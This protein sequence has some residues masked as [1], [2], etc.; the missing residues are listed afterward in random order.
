MKH[1]DALARRARRSSTSQRRL[2]FSQRRHAGREDD[3][4]AVAADVA[5]VRQIRDL[6]RGNLESLRSRARA[7]RSTLSQSNAVEKKLD[8][9]ALAMGHQRLMHVARTAPAGAASR[10]AIHRR[11]TLRSDSPLSRRAAVARRSALKVWNLTKSAPA[12]GGRFDQSASQSQVAVMVD[13]GLGDDECSHA[14]PLERGYC[15]CRPHNR[16]GPLPHADQAALCRCGAL[17]HAGVA[18]DER[19][20]S[21]AYAAVDGRGGRDV[22]VVADHGVMLHQRL[23]VDDAIAARPLRRR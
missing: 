11:P 21:D 9:R 16:R 4:L 6:A 5:K 17:S 12:V 8:V 18:A 1:G 15:R 22:A 19:A 20:S 14:A 2:D 3:R 23:A 13:A 10:A 7:N